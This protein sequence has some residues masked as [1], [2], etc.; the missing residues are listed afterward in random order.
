MAPLVVIEV[1]KKIGTSSLA[2]IMRKNRVGG[3]RQHHDP[4]N[5]A[6]KESL[7]SRNWS[8]PVCAGNT[9]QEYRLS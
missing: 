2:T 4:D 7:H 5:H 8:L 9:H 6:S 1:S 3:N